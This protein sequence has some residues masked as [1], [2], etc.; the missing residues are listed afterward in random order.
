MSKNEILDKLRENSKRRG[1]N[2]AKN[3]EYT[4]KTD[5]NAETK[6]SPQAITCLE[7]LFA[8]K[9]N[10]MMEQEII[11]LI[12]DNA[13][14]FGETKQSPWKIFQYY[15]KSLVNAGFIVVEKIESK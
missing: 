6:L 7:I 10:K 8:E 9:R 3:R 15:R 4:I 5:G 13:A 12:N 2:R 1:G 14:K 11:G